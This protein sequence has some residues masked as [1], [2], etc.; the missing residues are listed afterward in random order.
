MKWNQ[1]SK[2]WRSKMRNT[3]ANLRLIVMKPRRI[4][5]RRDNLIYWICTSWKVPIPLI[6]KRWQVIIL[7]TRMINFSQVLQSQMSKNQPNQQMTQ[8]TTLLN[9]LINKFLW[10]R[11]FQKMHSNRM[12]ILIWHQIKSRVTYSQ[13]LLRCLQ[14]KTGDSHQSTITNIV[15]T[16]LILTTASPNRQIP[17]PVHHQIQKKWKLIFLRETHQD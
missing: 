9:L 14:W 12:K 10:L 5:T 7:T 1:R 8:S 3:L 17:Q 15:S 16:I 6:W 11:C 4:W 13:N 2:V